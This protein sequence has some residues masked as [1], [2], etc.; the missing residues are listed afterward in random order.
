ML[1]IDKNLHEYSCDT[2]VAFFGMTTY[3]RKEQDKRQEY[4]QRWV[5]ST[6][7][8]LWQALVSMTSCSPPKWHLAANGSQPHHSEGGNSCCRSKNNNF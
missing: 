4:E 2:T 6:L 3:I 7:S 5:L 8:C 1:F